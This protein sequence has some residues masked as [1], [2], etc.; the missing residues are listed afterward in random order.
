MKNS[1]LSFDDK[2]MAGIVTT[3]KSGDSGGAIRQQI[4]DFAFAFVAPLSTNYNNVFTH[5][6]LPHKVEQ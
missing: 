2:R 5:I 3:L 6:K 4:D 1:L